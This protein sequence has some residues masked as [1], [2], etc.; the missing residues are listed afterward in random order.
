[1]VSHLNIMDIFL[2]Y[3]ISLNMLKDDSLF[4]N[5]R[6]LTMYLY[7]ITTYCPF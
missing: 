6:F 4:R 5:I 3:S 2:N 1:M 7:R